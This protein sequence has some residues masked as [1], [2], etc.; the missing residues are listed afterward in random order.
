VCDI[1]H[2]Y[3]T[4][5][6]LQGLCVC[7]VCCSVWRDSFVCDMTHSYVTWRIHM[8][9]DLFI[10]VTWLIHVW[11]DSFICVTW[12]IHMCGMTHSYVLCLWDT[13][14]A[15]TS[16][17]PVEVCVCDMTHPY[18]T[19]LIHMWHDSSIRDMTNSYICDSATS[20]G[21]VCV[22]VCDIVCVHDSSIWDMTHSYVLP[23]RHMWRVIFF[24]ANV[25]VCV[26][27]WHDSYIC[28]GSHAYVRHDSFI[29]AAY[30]I[31]HSPFGFFFR[32]CMSVGHV[33]VT[34]V[35]DTCVWHV[36]RA[37]IDWW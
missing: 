30:P 28:H 6:L 27:A 19:W 26:R 22:C 8:W 5:Q 14:H 15:A 29:C 13:C 7:V 3:V 36:S 31:R 17:G 33:C 9:Y 25:C 18:V 24:R 2:T 34:H 12:L 10:C 32:A 37:H 20:S 16:S 11:H 4:R 35:C 1:T 21:P 23:R